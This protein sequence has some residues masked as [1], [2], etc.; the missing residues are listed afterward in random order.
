MLAISLHRRGLY[1]SALA[2]CERA[3]A[4]E[5]CHVL[6]LIVR[7]DTLKRLPGTSSEL[8]TADFALALDLGGERAQRLI[9]KGFTFARLNEYCS[10]VIDW[11]PS[12]VCPLYLRTPDP[13]ESHTPEVPPAPPPLLRLDLTAENAEVLNRIAIFSENGSA[14]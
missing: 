7:G 5:A 13:T 14:A 11:L 4:L 6:S 9:G 10:A 12:L 8:S 1:A 2:C 3:L